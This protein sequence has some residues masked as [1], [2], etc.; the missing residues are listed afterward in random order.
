MVPVP[1]SRSNPPLRSDTL[2]PVR[3]LRSGRFREPT[4]L[5]L[6]DAQTR[7]FLASA[8]Q[9]VRQHATVGFTRAALRAGPCHADDVLAVLPR[10]TDVIVVG[11]QGSVV[12]VETPAGHGWLHE[13]ALG[14][15]DEDGAAFEHDD[16]PVLDDLPPTLRVPGQGAVVRPRASHLGWTDSLK[17]GTPVSLIEEQGGFVRVT[18]DGGGGWVHLT[19]LVTLVP[20]VY[21]LLPRHAA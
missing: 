8:S 18:Y 13:R 2:Q 14:A 17:P 12:Q 1:K 16:L 5:M 7:A 21:P 6:T 15:Y 3:R 19:S 9:P 10:Q 20:C 4:S 11:R